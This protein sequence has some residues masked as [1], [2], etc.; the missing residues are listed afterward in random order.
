MERGGKVF[1]MLAALAA[2][3]G[4]S[5]SDAEKYAFK[6]G[7]NPRKYELI[8]RGAPYEWKKGVL[9]L[10]LLYFYG[11]LSRV[12]RI[13]GYGETYTPLSRNFMRQ[14]LWRY[15]GRFY[16]NKNYC[17]FCDEYI[18]FNTEDLHFGQYEHLVLHHFRQLLVGP[19]D[20]GGLSNE[21]AIR[22]LQSLRK[23]FAGEM[24]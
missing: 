16:V 7:R 14:L 21:E 20:Y 15:C 18:D 9:L 17:I 8:M 24:R 13:L 6:E 22:R 2:E 3:E 5:L 1:E 12:R 11:N 23:Y 19:R 4:L 10:L